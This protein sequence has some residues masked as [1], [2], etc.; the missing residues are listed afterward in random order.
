MRQVISN[1]I[2]RLKKLFVDMAKNCAA[3]SF[4]AVVI[5]SPSV[6]K[7]KINLDKTSVNHF[8]V[9]IHFLTVIQ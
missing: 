5:V 6:R 9:Y 8:W 2:V 1:M 3:T 4:S 7:E